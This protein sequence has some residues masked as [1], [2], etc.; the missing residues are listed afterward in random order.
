MKIKMKKIRVKMA[1]P[2]YLGMLILYIS[3]TLM[4]EIWYDY[5]GPK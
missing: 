3:K 2:L 4:Y 5:I 1:K